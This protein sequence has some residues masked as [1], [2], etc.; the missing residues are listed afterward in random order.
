MLAESVMSKLLRDPRVVTTGFQREIHVVNGTQVVVYVAGKGEPLL[1]FHGAGTWQGFQF[2]RH[3]S[4]R[5]RVVAP[6][7]PGFGESE[8]Q[9]RLGSIQ[10]YVL[11]YLDL[12]DALGLEQFHLLGYSMGGRMAA[13]FAIQHAHRLRK[14][15]LACPAGLDVP[16][17][18]VTDLASVPPSEIFGYLVHDIERVR[19]CLPEGP[20]A[21]FIA[22][23]ER[24]AASFGRLLGPD[25]LTNRQL[26]FWLHRVKVPAL[27]LWGLKER[28]IPVAHA[29]AW[30]RLLPN[31]RVEVI[32]DAGHLVLDESPLACETAKQFLLD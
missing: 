2:L 21:E 10:D 1:Y 17:H 31:A 30:A 29:Q 24:E 27:V 16:D 5:F 25:G 18:P 14:L 22:M 6:Y 26:D 32:A 9:P 20:D 4:D 28:V 12:L 13:E 8:A 19:H 15:V 7:H 3:F 23:R 11:H